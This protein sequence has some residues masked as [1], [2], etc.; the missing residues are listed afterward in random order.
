MLIFAT[1]SSRLLVAAA[2]PAF[3]LT[4]ATAGAGRSAPGSSPSTPSSPQYGQKSV[5]AVET[6]PQTA[7]HLTLSSSFM[8]FS[9]LSSVLRTNASRSAGE[10]SGLN[11][12]P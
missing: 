8:P 6:S 4:L 5:S 1:L 11:A 9:F 2:M 12:T 3:V 7:V 10:A